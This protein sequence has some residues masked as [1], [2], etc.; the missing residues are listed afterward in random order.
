[1]ALPKKDK[2]KDRNLIAEATKEMNAGKYGRAS[3]LLKE[4]LAADA[5]NMEARRLFATLHLKTGNLITAKGAFDTLVKAALDAQDY[6][7]AESLLREYLAAGPRYIPFLE[8]LGEVLERKGDPPGA[9]VEYGKAIDVLV[10]DPDP[11]QPNRARELFDKI[12]SVAPT[13]P[14]VLRW[15]QT[16]EPTPPASA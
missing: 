1:M 9:A 12:K 5:K 11:D 2:E 6:W 14:V 10:E 7:L 4:I 13:S 3:S 15:A 16:F 8:K